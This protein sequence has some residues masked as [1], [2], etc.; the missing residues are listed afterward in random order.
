MRKLYVG[1]LPYSVTDSQLQKIFEQHGPVRSARVI[2][3]R[4]TG[5]SRGFGFVEMES[6]NAAREAMETLNQSQLDGR[7]LIVSEAVI[8]VKYAEWLARTR[9]TTGR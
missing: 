9:A 5:R 6:E 8:L 1:S 2:S 3:D 4:A 7:T